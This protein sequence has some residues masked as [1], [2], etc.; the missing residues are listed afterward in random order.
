MVRYSSVGGACLPASLPSAPISSRSLSF[1]PCSSRV[2]PQPPIAAR[3]LGWFCADVMAFGICSSV[4]C[5]PPLIDTKEDGVGFADASRQAGRTLPAVA[6][7]CHLKLGYL[8]L[9]SD[10]IQFSGSPGEWSTT[11]HSQEPFY[12]CCMLCKSQVCPSPALCSL[13]CGLSEV[14]R[15]AALGKRDYATA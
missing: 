8:S 2:G 1:S 5:R 13:S 15:F 7:A 10:W 4:P 9:D 12:R 3:R 11:V 14:S 6:K